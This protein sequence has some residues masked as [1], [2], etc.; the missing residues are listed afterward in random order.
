[1]VLFASLPSVV[2]RAYWKHAST[3]TPLS[4]FFSICHGR[5]IV[6]ERNMQTLK[7][8]TG[9]AVSYTT[10]YNYVIHVSYGCSYGAALDG[11]LRRHAAGDVIVSI[12]LSFSLSLF[13]QLFVGG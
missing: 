3:I 10:C 12:F 6:T 4:P 13:L 9:C 8:V 7:A 2:E 11:V 5:E 1:M